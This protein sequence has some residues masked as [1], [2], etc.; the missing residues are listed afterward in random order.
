MIVK[1][2]NKLLRELGQI[3]PNQR[4]KLLNKEANKG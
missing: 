3:C 2:K 4:A 1:K